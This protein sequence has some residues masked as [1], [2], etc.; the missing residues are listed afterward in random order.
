VALLWS[1]FYP[2]HERRIGEILKKDFPKAHVTLFHKVLPAIGGYQKTSTA[3]INAYTAPSAA[4]YIHTLTDFLTKEG[5]E[6]QFLFMQ[7]NGGVE[8]AEIG[9]ENPAT[10]ATSGPAQAPRL[11]LR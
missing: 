10:L 4:A 7:N 11:F 2:E 1:F 6:G 9:V 5:F 3:V 8:T